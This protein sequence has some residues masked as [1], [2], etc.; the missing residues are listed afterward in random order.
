MGNLDEKNINKIC[1]GSQYIEGHFTEQ[2]KC[3][4]GTLCKFSVKLPFP[5]KANYLECTALYTE[6]YKRYKASKNNI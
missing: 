2:I 1:L 3:L 4:L 6:Q 5:S